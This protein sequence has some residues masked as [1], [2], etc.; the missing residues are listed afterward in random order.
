M[1]EQ[2]TLDMLLSIAAWLLLFDAGNKEALEDGIRE[3]LE[4]GA[5]INKPDHADPFA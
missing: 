5:R 2:S 4:R 1:D 3:L